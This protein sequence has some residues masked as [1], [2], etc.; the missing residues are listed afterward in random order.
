MYFDCIYK[1]SRTKIPYAEY[2]LHVAR[3]GECPYRPIFC[4]NNCGDFRL[5]E[6]PESDQIGASNKKALK[7]MMPYHC[8]NCYMQTI[9]RNSDVKLATTLGSKFRNIKKIQDER[10]SLTDHTVSK[11]FLGELSHNFDRIKLDYLNGKKR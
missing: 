2:E 11:A 7:P 3:A 10:Q 9:K 4:I 6:L 1:C 8:E 5:P